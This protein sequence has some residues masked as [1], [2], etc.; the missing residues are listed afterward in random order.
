MTGRKTPIYLLTYLPTP[1]LGTGQAVPGAGAASGTAHTQATH[2]FLPGPEETDQPLAPR[3]QQLQPGQ[4]PPAGGYRNVGTVAP[5]GVPLIG[6]IPGDRNSWT[7]LKVIL[8]HKY[9]HIIIIKLNEVHIYR[10]QP[11]SPTKGDFF[12][13]IFV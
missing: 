12:S 4:H 11:K 9:R 3:E 13:Y 7:V 2:Q 10:L 1:R 6:K 5:R 8:G